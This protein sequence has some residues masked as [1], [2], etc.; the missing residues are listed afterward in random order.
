METVKS[1]KVV[2][3]L[4]G[5]GVVQTDGKEVGYAVNKCDGT[6][7]KSFHD[8]TSYAKSSFRTG[9][10]GLLGRDIKISGDGLR[11][12]IHVLEHPYHTPNVYIHDALKLAYIANIGTM[13]RGYLCADSGERRKSIYCITPA[14]EKSGAVPLLEQHSRSGAKT[15]SED[16]GAKDTT[17]FSRES[18]GATTYEAEMYIDISEA[19]F[20][21]LSDLADRRAINDDLVTEFRR[22]LGEQLGSTVPEPAFFVRKYSAYRT[23]EKGIQLDPQQVK[24]I[25]LDLLT[26]VASINISKSQAGYARAVQVVVTPILNGLGKCGKSSTV[27]NAAAG[28]MDF[29]GLSTVLD[30]LSSDYEK[31]DTDAA[32]ALIKDL[33]TRKK[34]EA[35]AKK[36]AKADKK[37]KKKPVAAEDTED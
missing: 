1:L 18:L 7:V 14:Y 25:V 35:D 9:K 10:E 30:N 29:R 26:K 3:T 16:G 34:A 20:I 27:F 33:E 21:P 8:N 17:I 28:E 4:Q 19:G 12:A 32:V 15:S 37:G 11:H 36:K 5:Q 22:I 6:L 2:I 13:Q 24:M 23:P 31:T